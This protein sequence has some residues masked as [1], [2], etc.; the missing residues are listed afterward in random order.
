MN[1]TYVREHQIFFDDMLAFLFA[2]ASMNKAVKCPSGDPM[3]GY[4]PADFIVIEG[5]PVTNSDIFFYPYELFKTI[6]ENKWASI[7]RLEKAP[8]SRNRSPNPEWL[9]GFSG[10]LGSLLQAVFVHFYDLSRTKMEEIFG[11]DEEVWPDIWK[12][13]K[14][15]YR[16][17]TNEN[18]L[19][20]P[21][22]NATAVTWKTLI[23]GP[24]D[25]GRQ[26]LYND[27]MPAD[28]LFLM[29]EMS[30][31]TTFFSVLYDHM[32]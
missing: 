27:L 20:F 10:V 6:Q 11:T 25:N 12:F 21:D 29:E 9:S 3:T 2:L 18:R 14:A 13:G 17:F 24:P 15:V 23:Y 26:L 1:L 31:S 5:S 4:Q 30:T 32:E 19:H 28:L 22:K 8:L 7:V 16:A